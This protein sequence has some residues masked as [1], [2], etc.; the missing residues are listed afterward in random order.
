MSL[1]VLPKGEIPHTRHVKGSNYALI[2]VFA[3]RLPGRA[4]IIC[5]ID[6]LVKVRRP[7]F[8][9]IL[10]CDAKS[11][12]FTS[13]GR[14]TI[15]CC[16]DNSIGCSRLP[17]LQRLHVCVMGNLMNS[18]A[19]SAWHQQDATRAGAAGDAANGVA[20]QPSALDAAPTC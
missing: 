3:D 1:Q 20:D 19:M 17:L 8:R 5:C 15:M 2:G 14:A 6:N 10:T 12:L 9:S 13:R 7:P 4:I 16:T 11:P 18:F